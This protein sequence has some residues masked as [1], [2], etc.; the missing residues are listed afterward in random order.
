MSFTARSTST[1]S[2]QVGPFDFASPMGNLEDAMKLQYGFA[3]T[4]CYFSFYFFAIFIDLHANILRD[5]AR[6]YIWHL[7]YF[8]LLLCRAP[9]RLENRTGKNLH[10]SPQPDVGR[11]FRK[12][13]TCQRMHIM[14]NITSD[15][16]DAWR[17]QHGPVIGMK[18]YGEKADRK[19]AGLEQRP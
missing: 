1:W 8:L 9:V 2:K 15:G 16:L 19:K 17:D 18:S 13:S 14:V 4:V 5:S 12:R 6:S 11:K 7:C 3:L 10:L